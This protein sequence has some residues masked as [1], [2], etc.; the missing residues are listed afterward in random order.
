M[1]IQY[2][3]NSAQAV[4][5][6]AHHV[7]DVPAIKRVVFSGLGFVFV[8]IGFIGIFLPGIPTT[9]PLIAA[10]FFLARGN[11]RLQRKL[12]GHRIFRSYLPYLDGSIAMP[13]R[14][15]M[16]AL[17]SMWI[18]ILVSCIFMSQTIHA[19]TVVMGLTMAMGLVGT[20]FILL[21]RRKES[22]LPTSEPGRPQESSCE[23]ELQL[24]SSLRDF[25]NVFQ[26][27]P[28]VQ[29]ISVSWKHQQMHE[30]LKTGE[31]SQ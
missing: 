9:G 28:F 21:Y 15:R 10:S 14:A 23:T 20:G 16:W 22:H 6:I 2:A 12:L 24:L 7:N 31:T 18:S 1:N 13:L 19:R 8:A 5:D 30:L 26:K 3:C 25:D 27:R 4:G 29:S 11:P 17:A